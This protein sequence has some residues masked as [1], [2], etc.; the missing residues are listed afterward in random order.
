MAVR[1]IV[2]AGFVQAAILMSVCGFSAAD[3]GES[4]TTGPGA[5]VDEAHGRAIQ[6]GQ[7]MVKLAS[8]NAWDGVDVAWREL[9]SLGVPVDFH[10]EALGAEA[11]RQRGQIWEAYQRSTL[12]LRLKPGDEG[13]VRQM[14]DFRVRFGRL[15]VR[16]VDATPL[17]L[18]PAEMPF[19]Q[20]ERRSIEVAMEQ[21]RATGAFDGMLPVG[22]Y[23]LGSNPVTISAGLT[24][25]IV[26]RKQ[27]ES[28]SR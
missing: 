5:A 6:L 14:E 10:L 21:L 24:P 22:A 12:V 20:D 9:H 26:Q 16:R 18:V 15:T 1:S 25:M 7:E 28:G 2:K 3:A 4:P 11:A 23:T 17:E 27:G 8:R 13:A 19:A